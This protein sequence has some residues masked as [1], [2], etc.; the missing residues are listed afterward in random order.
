MGKHW[1]SDYGTDDDDDEYNEPCSLGEGFVMRSSE[2]AL[3]VKLD[4]RPKEIWVPRSQI[5]NN[6]P[7]YH[8]HKA[9]TG[10]LIVKTGWAERAKLL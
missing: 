6:S 3:L 5:H 2:K 7:L 1:S 4:D 8:E 9:P 10:E